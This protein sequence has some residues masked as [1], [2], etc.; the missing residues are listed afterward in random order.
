LSALS[1]SE[2]SSMMSSS[3]S[4]YTYTYVG[5]LMIFSFFLNKINICFRTVCFSYGR[6]VE[7]IDRCKKKRFFVSYYSL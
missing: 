3:G 1:M 2:M 6:Y 4:A 7:S 5:E